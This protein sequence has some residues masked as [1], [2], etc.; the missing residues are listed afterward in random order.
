MSF[1]IFDSQRRKK[2]SRTYLHRKNREVWI[3]AGMSARAAPDANGL[4]N[5]QEEAGYGNAIVKEEPSDP[6]ASTNHRP[7]SSP[8]AN[9]VK[10]AFVYTC[11]SFAIRE[12]A[13]LVAASCRASAA[14][15]P[16]A[17]AG[18]IAR[19]NLLLLDNFTRQIHSR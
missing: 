6:I 14:F 7:K 10:K 3:C 15:V 2:I 19:N 16:T 11:P 8:E 4:A 9:R 17:P 5:A 12:N 18:N 13:S 1:S